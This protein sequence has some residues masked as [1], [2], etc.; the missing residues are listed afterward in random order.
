MG[1][2][3]GASNPNLW[4]FAAI[5]VEMRKSLYATFNA[6]IQILDLDLV[7]TTPYDPVTDTGGVSVPA[8]LFDSGENGALIQPLGHP[9]KT[10]FGEQAQGLEGIRF[11]T[12]LDLPT[13][14]LRSGLA[15][16]VKNGGNDTTLQRYLFQI[17]DGLDSSIAWGRIIEATV[18]TGGVPPLIE[19][20]P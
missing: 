10:S 13:G 8:V 16:V 12:K 11:Q 15:V 4:D 7:S 6:H 14:A 5:G 3:A 19:E 20:T 9:S 2:F 17:A 1:V 18:V